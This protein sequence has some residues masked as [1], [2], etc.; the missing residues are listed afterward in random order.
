MKK[1][2]V[3]LMLL[4]PAP[5]WAAWGDFEFIP[6]EELIGELDVVLPAY[7]LTKNLIAFDAS[8]LTANRHFIDAQS[9]KVG[10]DRIIR[11]TVVIDTKGGARNVS[12]E[13]M[14]CKPGERKLYAY[15]RPDAT[16]SMAQTPTW[17]AINFNS[18]TSYHRDLYRE[19]F[20]PDEIAVKDAA[21][22]I[23]NLRR[24]GR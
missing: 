8:T 9:I 10:E 5:T 15:G 7:P 24:A 2:L 20:C 11:Y 16:W 1:L 23:A 22:A 12:Y 13:G 3:L 21:E 6:N 19:I 18:A 17:Q 14:R 4:L